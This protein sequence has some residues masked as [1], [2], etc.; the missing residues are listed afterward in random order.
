M[1]GMGPDGQLLYAGYLV[2]F[3]GAAIACLLSALRARAVKDPDTRRGLLALLLTSSGWAAAHVAFLTVPLGAKRFMYLVGLT[4]GISAVGAWL[5]FC[6]AY[7]NRSLHRQPAYRRAAVAVFAVIFGIKITNPLHKLYSTGEFVT[8]PFPHLAVT[9]QLTHWLVMGLAYGLS[10]VG[11]FMLLEHFTKV[12]YDTR[13]L[14]GLAALTGLP[15]VLDIVGYATPYLID[16]NYEPIGV[17]AFA[18]GVVFVYLDRFQTVQMAANHTDPILLLSSDDRIRDY[19]EPAARLFPELA[20]TD[21]FGEPLW[22]TVPDII[23]ALETEQQIIERER[24]GKSRY[25]RIAESP[26]TA[27]EAQLGRLLTFTDITDRETYRQELERQNNRLEQF[28]GMVSH[29]LRNPLSVAMARVEIAH[30]E[31]GNEHLDVAASALD[32][33]ETLISDV[34]ALARNGQPIDATEPVSLST[35]ATNCWDMVDSSAATLE[36][37][38]D[39]T[40]VADPNRLRQL[41]EN[42][43]RNSLEHG[44][45][46]VTITVGSLPDGSGFYVADNGPGIPEDE[47]DDVFETGY[48]TATSGTG[49]GLAIVSEIAEAHEWAMTLTESDSGG[50]RIEIRGVE[51]E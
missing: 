4:L 12:N 2:A 29:D 28:A 42:L 45:Q 47:R 36:I 35:I 39:L 20:E 1:L 49:F 44:R 38:G 27:Q 41:L 43:F 6:S 48:S 24:N 22:A 16:I 26:F 15:I 18:V 33:M 40:F 51:T 9:P 30:E 7:T 21:V 17:A 46:D 37:D 50:V 11:Y 14:L 13:P 19:N 32:R 34:L 5:Y 31:T 10:M 8:T 23:D 25:Y 3:G